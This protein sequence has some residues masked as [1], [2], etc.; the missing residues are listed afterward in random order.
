MG[1]RFDIINEDIDARRSN[2]ADIEAHACSR[3][4]HSRPWIS[5]IGHGEAADWSQPICRPRKTLEHLPWIH[6]SKQPNP[7]PLQKTRCQPT[8]RK[9]RNHGP[10]PREQGRNGEQATPHK[11]LQLQQATGR[12]PKAASAAIKQPCRTRQ[13]PEKRRRAQAARRQTAV[14]EAN[15]A[16][17][18]SREALEAERPWK[19]KRSSW[20]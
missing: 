3:Q 12:R 1:P 13:R 19:R 14:K 2:Q 7:I 10:I 4:Q 17:L 18:E 11:R 15:R 6:Q 9:H 8:L 20:V 16:K 5:K